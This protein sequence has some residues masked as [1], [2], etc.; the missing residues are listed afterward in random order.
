MAA[1]TRLAARSHEDQQHAS[2]ERGSRAASDLT[3]G[4]RHAQ[5]ELRNPEAGEDPHEEGRS[6]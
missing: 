2:Y 3:R 5:V 1:D 4:H 6:R